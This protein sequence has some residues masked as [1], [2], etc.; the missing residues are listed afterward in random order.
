LELI[1]ILAKLRKF[2]VD[3]GAHAGS[4]VGGA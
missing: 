3:G 1:L 2:D 4:E